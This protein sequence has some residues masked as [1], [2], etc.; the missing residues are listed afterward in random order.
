MSTDLPTQLRDAITAKLELAR[1]VHAV[2]PGSW[3]LHLDRHTRWWI[4]DPTGDQLAEVGAQQDAA[5]IAANDP[6]SVIRG[7]E[8]DLR[9]LDR[10]T[11]LD[12]PSKHIF[13]PP[14]C[15]GGDC[16]HCGIDWPCPDV[17]DLAYDLGIP[18]K[19]ET[20]G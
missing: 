4:L 20:D 12:L 1:A 17:V 3:R 16:R 8:R 9:I 14:D 13:C 10:H 18:T 2:D 7:C 6:A 19:E 11:L 5:H 15:R